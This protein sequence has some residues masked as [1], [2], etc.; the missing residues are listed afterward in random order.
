MDHSRS[1]EAVGG[2]PALTVRECCASLN[3]WLLFTVFG[4]GTGLG[5]MFVN[6][7]GE[8][9]IRP[10]RP[11]SCAKVLDSTYLFAVYG[12]GLLPIESFDIQQAITARCVSPCPLS[13]S[14]LTSSSMRVLVPDSKLCSIVIR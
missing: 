10:L 5:L 2:P 9:H 11:V 12:L 13:H 3:F 6:N 8:P 1:A 4:V 7:L 14:H